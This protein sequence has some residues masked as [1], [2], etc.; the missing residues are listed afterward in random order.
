GGIRQRVAGLRSRADLDVVG[1][2]RDSARGN[3]RGARDHPFPTILDWLDTATREA[4]VR[5]VV[6]A[7]QALN[8]GLL[9]LVHHFRALARVGVDLVD[10]LVVDLHLEVLRPAAV[11]PQPRPCSGLWCRSSFHGDHC[12]PWW[13]CPPPACGGGGRAASGGVCASAAFPSRSGGRPA[14]SERPRART[15]TSMWR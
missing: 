14:P 15:V 7:V 1:L 2:D 9:Q 11:A 6:H 10:A 3:P 13:C 5:L 8:D 12:M 4:E